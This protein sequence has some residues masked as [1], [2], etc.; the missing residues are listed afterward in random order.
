MPLMG[1]NEIEEAALGL[2]PKARPD[3]RCALGRHPANKP[4]QPTSGGQTEVD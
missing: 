4:P 2:E 3:A 1:I